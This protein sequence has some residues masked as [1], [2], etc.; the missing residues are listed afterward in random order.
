MLD[1]GAG[2]DTMIGGLGN[3]TYVVDNVGDVVIENAN[4]G[5]DTVL[6]IAHY[7]AVGA[8][9]ENLTLHGSANLQGNGNS[10][11]NMHPGNAGNNLLDGGAGAD[12]MVG[13]AGNDTYLVDNAGDAVIENANEGTDTVLATVALQAGAN[14]ENLTLHGSADLQG[15]GNADANVIYRQCRQQHPRRR[16]RRRHHGRRRRQR[17]L[18][19]RQC[20]RRGDRERRTRAPT[21]CSRPP[22]TRWRPTSRT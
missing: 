16:G 18:L 2:A 11:A 6:S 13:G 19:R 8:N 14:V 4:E 20:R 17:H 7:H 1:G 15:Y 21:R 22:T 9:V 12:T 10:A 3:D 5:T